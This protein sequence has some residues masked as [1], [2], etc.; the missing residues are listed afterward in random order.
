MEVVLC[1]RGFFEN[2][3][4]TSSVLDVYGSVKNI[5]GCVGLEIL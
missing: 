1:V 5:Y 2:R 3:G 4:V